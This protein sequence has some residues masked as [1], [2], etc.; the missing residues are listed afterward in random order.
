M[1]VT[2]IKCE[3]RVSANQRAISAYT[4]QVPIEHNTDINIR[5]VL[6]LC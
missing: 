5:R 2:S 3:Q 1:V 6:E 4:D